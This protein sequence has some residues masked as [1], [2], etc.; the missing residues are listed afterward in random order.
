LGDNWLKAVLPEDVEALTQGWKKAITSNTFSTADYRFL[1]KDGTVKWIS[2]KAVPQKNS[3]GAV[4]GYIGT[5]VDI[6]ERKLSEEKLKESEE[7][8]RKLIEQAPIGFVL[9]DSAQR[10][11]FTNK[12]FVELTGYTVEDHPT[13]DEWWTKAYPDE[14]YRDLIKKEWLNSIT[15]ALNTGTDIKPFE[16]K[17]TCKD[18]SVKYLEI[19]FVS[20]GTFNIVSFVDIT[21][22]KN[23]EEELISL[24][25][26]LEEKVAEQTLELNQKISELENFKEITINREYRI[27]ELRK[28]LN[29]LKR[30]NRE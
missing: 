17:V 16:C 19:G 7:K 10:T 5:A 4:I 20:A 13:V 9:S 30:L 22:R 1:W 28:E 24:K 3:E 11:L 18:G 14:E 15:A 8:F 25:D 23:V 29:E 21:E 27:M 6:T 26:K 2:G 12:K